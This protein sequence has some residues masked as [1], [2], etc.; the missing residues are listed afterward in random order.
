MAK[1]P[2]EIK[3]GYRITFNPQDKLLIVHDG[4]GTILKWPDGTG[5][6]SVSFIK[7]EEGFYRFA[8]FLADLSG[9][10]VRKI[11]LVSPNRIGCMFF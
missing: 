7:D 1:T 2:M 6:T 4:L 10:T 9:L 8:C 11:D 5:K 3:A